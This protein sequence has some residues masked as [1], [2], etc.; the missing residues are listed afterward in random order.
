MADKKVEK[1]FIHCSD[2]TWGS[3]IIIDQWH[4][5]RG[6]TMI[7]YLGVILNGFPVAG[8]KEPWSFADGSWEWGRA[9]NDDTTL[10]DSEVEAQVYGWNSKSIGICLIGKPEGPRNRSK[11]TQAQLLT[12]RKVV[13]ALMK[14]FNLTPDAVLGHYE[15]EP[16]KSC[17]GLDMNIYRNWLKDKTSLDAIIRDMG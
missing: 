17:P 9:L 12:S 16:A 8:M 3:A 7:G 5:Q 6:W 11:F 2:S 4:K 15:A 1:I 14:H 10:Q 13:E